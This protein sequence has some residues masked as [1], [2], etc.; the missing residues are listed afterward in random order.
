MRGAAAGA[1]GSQ[2][3]T[4]G[5]S[6]LGKLGKLFGKDGGSAGRFHGLE[7]GRLKN[8]AVVVKGEHYQQ[9]LED[10]YNSE[11]FQA[12][13]VDADAAVATV[14]P[15][16]IEGVDLSDRDLED[17]SGFWSMHNSSQEFFEQTAAHIPDVQAALDSGRSLEELKSD[18]VLGDCAQTFFEPSKMPRVEKWGDYYAFDGDG[19]HRI[20]TARA[21]GYDIPVRITRVRRRR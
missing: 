15:A 14:S 21:L 12:E 9:F 17:S 11:G 16:Q 19:R 13:Q 7:V 1:R 18:P 2:S 3:G 4:K 6:L 20:I 5:G 10:Y 8:G